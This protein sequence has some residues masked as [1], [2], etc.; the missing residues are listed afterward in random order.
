MA[1]EPYLR[2]NSVRFRGSAQTGMKIVMIPI[3][4]TAA[5]LFLGSRLDEYEATGHRGNAFKFSEKKDRIDRGNLA[6]V[7]IVQDAKTRHILQA[8]FVD[9]TPPAPQPPTSNAGN[10]R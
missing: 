3:C 1:C 7:V 8:A 5:T 9:L 4:L 10:Q 2:A 6:A